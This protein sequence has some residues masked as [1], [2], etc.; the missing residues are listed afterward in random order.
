MSG[1]QD[2]RCL[3]LDEVPR[4]RSVRVYCPSTVDLQAEWILTDV[5]QFNFPGTVD[6][7]KHA[8]FENMLPRIREMHK[9]LWPDKAV[10]EMRL[11]RKNTSQRVH[12]SNRSTDFTFDEKTIPTTLMVAAVVVWATLL[13][14]KND[15]REISFQFLKRM[16]NK[17]LNGCDGFSKGFVDIDRNG[18]SNQPMFE[19]GHAEEARKAWDDDLVNASAYWV[20]SNYDQPHLADV[21]GFSLKPLPKKSLTSKEKKIWRNLKPSL[22]KAG[23][24]AVVLFTEAL[25]D[26]L[27][28]CTITMG[29]KRKAVG[30]QPKPTKR[31]K[32]TIAEITEITA[33]TV[34]NLY[35]QKDRVCEI[36]FCI[37]FQKQFIVYVVKCIYI[38][39]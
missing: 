25:H 39:I 21:I 31:T 15:Q 10:P 22:E 16:I 19:D 7:N 29:L 34:Q 11:G 8:R 24:Q 5:L 27:K 26:H 32:R 9:T 38:A 18:V 4:L 30:E 35:D 3:V 37:G 36:L 1:F 17:V 23:H 33:K 14:R 2:L 12:G 6:K 13:S 28:A 20:R